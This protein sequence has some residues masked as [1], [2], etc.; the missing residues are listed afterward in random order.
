L[1]SG[2]GISITQIVSTTPRVIST[3]G[4]KSGDLVIFNHT[5]GRLD[6]EEVG[7]VSLEIAAPSMLSYK[8]ACLP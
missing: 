7:T 6:I 3:S 5:K 4:I 2:S 1:I 8:R